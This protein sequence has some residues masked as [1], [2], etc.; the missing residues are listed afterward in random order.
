MKRIMLLVLALVLL[1]ASCAQAEVEIPEWLNLDGYRP[2]VKE[3][4][5]ESFSIAGRVK[6]SD[7]TS[8][9][10]T[11]W[12]WLFC[13]QKMNLRL[14]DIEQIKQS[15]IP[16]R[17]PLMFASGDVSDL[18]LS[19]GFTPEELMRYGQ[20]EGMLLP[21]QDYITP[22][23]TPTLYALR[24]EMPET[25]A[26]CFAPDGN[27][28]TLPNF[29]DMDRAYS[30]LS[31]INTSWLEQ[32]GMSKPTTLNELIEVL[33][34]FKTLGDDVV[35]IGGAY[36]VDDPRLLIMYAYGYDTID[37]DGVKPGLKN[38]EVVIPAYTPEFA[39]YLKTMNQ[40]YTEGLIDK[41]FF[42][43]DAL[44]VHAQMSDGK[45]G[46]MCIFPYN[47]VDNY[48]EWE[49]LSP[50]TSAINDQQ[51]WTG[52]TYYNIGNV[53]VS[54]DAEN[55]ELVM[56]FVDYL[57]TAEGRL[58]SYNGPSTNKAIEEN[59]QGSDFMGWYLDETYNEHFADVEKEGSPYS[60]G[61]AVMVDKNIIWAGG[62]A[63]DIR[64]TSAKMQA[65]MG[66][67]VVGTILS[68]ENGDNHAR[69]SNNTYT[70]PYYTEGYPSV[71]WMD[72]D[73]TLRVNDLYSV[74][75]TY[76]VKESAK[77]ITGIRPLEEVG[78]FQEE[79]KALNV[80]EYLGY[81]QEAYALQQASM[82]K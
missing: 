8:D 66:M 2:I 81:Y 29:L 12:F 43:A 46:M 28:Y 48:K 58:Y 44:E 34:A 60:N 41:D 26:A 33:R 76:V 54:V 30:F 77:F 42:T 51:V 47:Y 80:E 52:P 73:T 37:A 61:Y 62:K 39:E 32:V 14:N 16:D 64:E 21:L 55:P 45:T 11:T 78:K 79:L 70:A 57:Y 9:P 24:E 59:I 65:M 63:A 74:L 50:L 71:V 25:F 4:Y 40:L 18:L 53:A 49:C 15:A 1:C 38:G 23:L 56:R 82:T 6:D 22:E 69:L 3:G 31:F 7:N 68:T 35:P 20:M 27:M 5:D 67:E 19:F 36:G 72:E 10:E 13:D 17:I 75:S